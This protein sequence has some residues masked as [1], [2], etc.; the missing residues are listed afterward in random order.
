MKLICT[1]CSWVKPLMRTEEVFKKIFF[2]FSLHHCAVNTL[3]NQRSKVALVIRKNIDKI[4]YSYTVQQVLT[5]SGK[6]FLSR[7]PMSPTFLFAFK[8]GTNFPNNPIPTATSIEYFQ[9][10]SLEE[11]VSFIVEKTNGYRKFKM[12]RSRRCFLKTHEAETTLS[13]IYNFFQ[14]IS[15]KR[16]RFGIKYFVLCDC[17]TGFVLNFV[18]YAGSDSEITKTNDE[19]LRTSA[20]I[21]LALFNSYLRKGHTL[22]VEKR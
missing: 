22:I 4:I 7:F 21:V 18:L 19:Y 20:E 2:T 11:L 8:I 5:L 3:A 17:K 6:L 13:Q 1:S 16:N 9:Q 15:S 12:D 10:F 14:Y